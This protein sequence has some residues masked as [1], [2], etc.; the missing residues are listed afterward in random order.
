M[1]RQT[2]KAFRINDKIKC[3]ESCPVIK[4]YYLMIGGGKIGTN[5]L[6]YAK[7][8]KFPFVLVIDKDENAP[9]SREAK[10]LKTENELVNLLKNKALLAL[11]EDKP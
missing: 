6:R 11:P 3:I 2:N 10:I 5:F 7:R 9:A 1:K 4:G 8:N